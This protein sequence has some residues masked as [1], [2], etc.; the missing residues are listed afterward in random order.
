MREDARIEAAL[1]GVKILAK[2]DSRACN[3]FLTYYMESSRAN[4]I[5]SQVRLPK[6]S[7]QDVK[8]KIASSI[9]SP[10]KR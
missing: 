1:T 9:P 2:L 8:K 5:C 10:K 3:R 4:D 7:D 6:F